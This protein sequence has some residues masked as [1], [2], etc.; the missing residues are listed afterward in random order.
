ME[1]KCKTTLTKE[2]GSINRERTGERERE[3]TIWSLQ[4]EGDRNFHN[5]TGSVLRRV[6]RQG[7]HILSKGSLL[8]LFNLPSVKNKFLEVIGQWAMVVAQL[9]ERSLP[10]PVANL[11]NILQS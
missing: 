2:K 3:N 9:A 1:S 4:R 10:T 8:R 11:I 5:E 6:Q 7:K